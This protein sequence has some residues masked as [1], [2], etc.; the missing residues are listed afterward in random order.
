M[1]SAYAVK[2]PT[3]R[4]STASTVADVMRILGHGQSS[5]ARSTSGIPITGKLASNDEFEASNQVVQSTWACCP[6][7]TRGSSCPP[8]QSLSNVIPA[9]S[10]SPVVRHVCGDNAHFGLLKER[11]ST[12]ELTRTVL[13]ENQ[14]RHHDARVLLTAVGCRKSLGIFFRVV[15]RHVQSATLSLYFVTS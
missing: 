2:E 7:S 14:S 12:V 15:R 3:V 4:Y 6:K 11:Q 5:A 9:T 1:P 13:N 10:R 8:K